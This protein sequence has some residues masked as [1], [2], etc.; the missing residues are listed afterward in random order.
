MI[1]FIAALSLRVFADYTS[2]YALPK[3]T[4]LVKFKP[5]LFVEELSVSLIVFRRVHRLLLNNRQCRKKSMFFQHHG[6]TSKLDSR[7]LKK[8]V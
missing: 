1:Q 5:L 4:I 3:G 6:Y 7:Y 8:N 2:K